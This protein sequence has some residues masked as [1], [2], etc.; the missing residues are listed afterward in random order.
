MMVITIYND[1]NTSQCGDIV[2]EGLI[3]QYDQVSNDTISHI[4]VS[5]GWCS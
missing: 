3:H 2:H 4:N 5:E 1:D